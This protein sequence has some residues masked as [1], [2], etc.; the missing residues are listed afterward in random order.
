MKH[1]EVPNEITNLKT[2][3]DGPIL[4]PGDKVVYAAIR[5]HMNKT[6]RSC[7]PGT[8]RIKAIARCGY[9]KLSAAI[10]RL[11]KAG[12]ITL[13]KSMKNGRTIHEYK[14]PETEF[15]KS[16]EMF[17]D[18]FLNMD[19]PINVKEYY[20]D[21]QPFLYNKESGI[22]RC[23]F[24]N[25]EISKRTGWTIPSIKKYNRELMDK[26]LLEEE[27]TSSY[28]E[29]GLPIVSKNFNLSNLQ[30]AALWAQAITKQVVDNTEAIEEIQQRM[31]KMEE[32]YKKEIAR[33]QKELSKTRNTQEIYP[34]S[35][36]F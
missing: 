29:A 3:S 23:S 36:E 5:S 28:D 10:D 31:D 18:E 9:S 13:V 11:I 20:M 16:F 24:S 19:L 14:F 32:D 33:L 27:T 7:Y 30:Q 15:D 22:G 25:A 4:K 2:N 21:L 17:T 34:E 35:F 1:T 6:T 8:D 26:G 12:L